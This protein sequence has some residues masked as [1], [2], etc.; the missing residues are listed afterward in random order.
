MKDLN[1]LLAAKRVLLSD[2]AWGTQ[3]SQRGL[4]PG[5]CPEQWN[6]DR[7]DDVKAVASSYVG[8]GSDIILSNTFG[9]NPIKLAKAGLKGKTREVNRLGANISKEAAG[10]RALVFASVGPTGEFM[11]PLGDI[12]EQQMIDCFAEQIRGLV[13]G[14]ADGIVIETFTDLG[15]A[16]AALR[17]AREVVGAGHCFPPACGKLPVVISMTYSRGP[18]GFATM[19]GVRPDQ[20]ARELEAAG[21]DLVGSNCG[22]GI[23]DMIEV[24]ALMRPTTKLPLWIKPNAG[25][26]QLVNGKTIFRE[27]PEQMAA[28][29]PAL[30]KAGANVVGG[31]CGTTPEHIRQLARQRQMMR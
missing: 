3:L 11:E 19:M 30:V 6:F 17:A 10:D 2:G 24:A 16:K 20:A 23:A 12:T 1:A 28:Q 27:T 14:G 29:F 25:L 21:V 18:A 22:T 31:C 26:P 4:Q 13:E 15:E 7:R 5:E 8:A 9:G